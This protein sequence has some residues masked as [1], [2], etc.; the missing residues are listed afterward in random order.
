MEKDSQSVMITKNKIRDA[1]FKLY[2]N[3]QINKISIKEIMDLAGLNRGTFYVYYK[4]IYDL[5]E[6][7]ENELFEQ[8]KEK[9]EFVLAVLLRGEDFKQNLPSLEFLH[10][11][12]DHLKVL[13]GK[14]G[15]SK[16][17]LRIKNL[18]KSILKRKLSSVESEKGMALEYVLEYITSAQLGIMN[19]WIQRDLEM[20]VETLA[21]MIRDVNLNG[22]ISYLLEL[23][24]RN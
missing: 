21:E 17:A 8:I 15:D 12:K 24:E 22:P 19:Y 13:F 16:M 14:N 2:Q 9:V 1:F 20:P 7:T 4:D 10:Q 18:A 23:K 5:L 6:K 3:R 11:N